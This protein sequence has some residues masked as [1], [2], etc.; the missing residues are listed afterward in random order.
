[1][2]TF[3]TVKRSPIVLIRT[4]ALVELTFLAI[5]LLATL[6]D[7]YKLQIF[8]R[9]FFAKLFSYDTFKLFFLS[10]VQL[11]ITV[12]VFLRWYYESYTV[13]STSVSHRW[14]VFFKKSKTVPLHVLTAITPSQG[15]FGKLFHC[16]SLR[17]KNESASTSL[18]VADVSRHLEFLR[19]IRRA[20]DPVSFHEPPDVET[21]LSRDE[22]DRLEFKLSL[23]VDVKSQQVNRALEKAVMKTVA[24]FLN[25]KGGHLVLGVNDRREPVGLH[26]DYGTLQRPDRDGFEN[27]FTQVFNAMVGPEFRHLVKLWF[28]AL[29]D[30][31]ICVVQVARSPRPVYLSFDGGEEFF[32]RTGNITT[33]LKLSEVD[34]YKR[35]RWPSRASERM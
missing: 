31:E 23:R 29:N 14:G 16:G 27:H 5:Y 15:L 20:A 28:H 13:S 3:I 18:V 35:S 1:M 22:H 25:T 6:P 26:H 11:A 7:A 8:N 19:V 30:A 32:V 10:A 2:T 9:L 4:L 33:A 12:F 24:A 34:S 21:L 17:I